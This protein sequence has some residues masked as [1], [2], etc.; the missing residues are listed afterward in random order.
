[1]GAASGALGGYLAQQGGATGTLGAVWV[2]LDGLSSGAS[3]GW[4]VGKRAGL[5]LAGGNGEPVVKGIGALAL[6]FGS[7]I[8]GGV[9]GVAAGIAC[10]TAGPLVCAGVMGGIN[11][12]KELAS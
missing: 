6:T 7:P 2:G 9:A 4:A 11:L 12:V 8:V 3:C 10:A 1:M 5:A